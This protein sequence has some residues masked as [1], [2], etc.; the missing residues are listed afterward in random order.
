[1]FEIRPDL[2]YSTT[3]CVGGIES[4]SWYHERA[5]GSDTLLIAVGDSWTWGD[6]L[7]RIN[8]S[9]GIDDDIEF[10]TSH[11][12][13]NLIAE[14]F[15]SD[16]INIGYPGAS[17]I[18]I[19]RS[20]RECLEDVATK[21]KTVRVIFTLTEIG[22][23]A[24]A[25]YDELDVLPSACNSTF[26][27]FLT[28]YEHNTFVILKDE[29]IA[30]YKEVSFLFGRNFTYSFNENKKI[31]GVTHLPSTWVDCLA[32]AQECVEYPKIRILSNMSIEP[33]LGELDKLGKRRLLKEELEA[34]LDV[35]LD[36]TTW[37]VAS[38][39]NYKK[40]TK[41]PTVRGHEIWADYVYSEFIKLED[42][43]D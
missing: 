26:T 22:R 27:D 1:M 30:K 32:G 36:A 35:A 5:T 23:E 41:H 31:L 42:T 7:G 25:G 12:Y 17:N 3:M 14:K 16:F 15:R 6:S 10:R 9:N 18:L 29:L 43:T 4:R 19:L 11:I 8:P 33:L 37:L 24:D 13:G 2:D 38:E 40:A 28:E 21:Y 34:Y 39:L 20:L